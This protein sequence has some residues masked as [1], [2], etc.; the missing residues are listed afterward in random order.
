MPRFT[1]K[2]TSQNPPNGQSKFQDLDEVVQERVQKP[3]RTV[4]QFTFFKFQRSVNKHFK[5][6]TE[7]GES[8]DQKYSFKS[9]ERIP[10]L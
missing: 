6:F 9:E 8:H 2:Q 4:L 3:G 7:F 5:R 1:E 10:R